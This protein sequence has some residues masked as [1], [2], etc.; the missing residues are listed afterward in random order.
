MRQIRPAAIATAL[1]VGCLVVYLANGRTLPLSQGWDTIPNRLIPFS[2][3]LTG[4][5][6]LDIFLPDAKREGGFREYAQPRRGHLVSFYPVGA[7]VVALPVYVPIAI[8]LMA[9]ERWNHSEA[10]AISA[11]AEKLAAGVLAAA[12]VVFVF[13]L[14]LRLSSRQT[15]TAI[16]IVY[17]LGTSLW[18]IASQQLWQH[19]PAILCF[20]VGW[21]CLTRPSFFVRTCCAGFAFGAAAAVRPQMAIF[22]VAAALIL[23]VREWA[24]GITPALSALLTF[25]VAASLPCFAAASYNYRWYGSYVGGYAVAA[26]GF[27]AQDLLQGTLGLLFSPNRGLLFFAPAAALGIAGAVMAVRWWREYTDIAL[28]SIAA[29]PYFIFHASF[30]TWAGGWTYGPRY[31]T[32]L[33]PILAIGAA[34][35]LTR[36]PISLLVSVPLAAWSVG[37]QIIGAFCFPAANWSARMSPS[38]EAHAWDWHHLQIVEEFRSA[39]GHQ[40]AIDDVSSAPANSGVKTTGKRADSNSCVLF[41]RGAWVRFPKGDGVW[42]GEVA[43][44]C[45]PFLA[46]VESAGVTDYGLYCK[47][48]WYFYRADGSQ[49]RVVHSSYR[50]NDVPVP[51]DFDGDRRTDLVIY[52]GGAWIGFDPYTGAE[53][54]GIWTGPGYDAIPLPM[55][56]DGDG[57]ADFTAFQHGAWH[58]Y[59]RDGTYDHGITVEATAD[60][61]PVPADYTGLGIDVPVMFR[62]DGSW[63]FIDIRTGAITRTVRTGASGSPGHSPIPTPYD[64]DGDGTVDYGV[65]TSGSWL[66]F[67]A[68]GSPMTGFWTSGF[69]GDI[70]L[71]QRQIL[72]VDEPTPAKPTVARGA[73]DQPKGPR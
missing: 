6:T 35:A 68:D 34:V 55:D 70:P 53:K 57:K 60:D 16:A 51:R 63:N 38:I 11:K 9:T 27:H 7:A 31:L 21:W 10:Y 56:Y 49:I 50:E 25:G 5:T 58:F 15:A 29:I 65:Y 18:A 72:R 8:R 2:L 54:W 32:E 3:L 40:Y 4:T 71:S 17:G 73:S 69:A 14:A 12:S 1:F 66:F 13:L 64:Y 45:V 23:L 42:T 22:I 46:N 48:D 41:R 33:F 59:K 39:T 19:A 43:P 20:V 52:R 61:V 62:R 26:G 28:F 44:S 67:K 36:L 37:V 30:Y 24:S 47:G